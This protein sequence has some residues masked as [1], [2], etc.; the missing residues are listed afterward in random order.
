V[1]LA[2]QMIDRPAGLGTTCQLLLFRVV[3]V[4]EFIQQS[5]K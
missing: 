3:E 1:A 4:L 2:R 5:M